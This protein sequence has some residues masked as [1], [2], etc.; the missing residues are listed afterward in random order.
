[1]PRGAA[2]TALVEQFTTR[3]MLWPRTRSS[4]RHILP[5]PT[6]AEPDKG[7]NVSRTGENTWSF[8]ETELEE[9]Q[10]GISVTAVTIFTAGITDS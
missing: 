6:R 10:A 3:T 7:R 2:H 9:L 1:M 4:V 8:G 5:T